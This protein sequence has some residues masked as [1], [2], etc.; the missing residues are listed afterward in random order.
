LTSAAGAS[1]TCGMQ[2]LV[3]HQILIG[4]AITLAG[5]FGL[6]SLLLF[7]RGGGAPHVALA[8]AAFV[9]MGALLVYFRAVRARWN[10]ARRAELSARRGPR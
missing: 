4:A 1:T 8:A 7:S 3:A 5:V 9:V 6:R 10:E 2:L